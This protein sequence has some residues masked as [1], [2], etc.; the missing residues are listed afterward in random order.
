MRK[1]FILSILIMSLAFSQDIAVQ[2]F[3]DA[4]DIYTA[5][6]DDEEITE[7]Q[8][9]D[10]LQLFEEK[11]EINSGNLHRLRVIPGVD[12]ADIEVLE[13]ILEEK[14]DFHD[15]DD[16][17]FNYPG[18]FNLIESFIIVIPPSKRKLNGYA[19]VYTRRD[20]FSPSDWDDPYHKGKFLLRSGKWSGEIGFRQRGKEIG[21]VLNRMIKYRTTKLEFIAGNYRSKELG[22]GLLVGK[23]LWVPTDERCGDQLDYFQ[24]PYYGYQ[25]G[26]YAHWYLNKKWNFKTALSTN[27]FNAHSYQHLVSGAVSYAPKK[28]GEIGIVLYQGAI[29][30]FDSIGT[31]GFS[32]MGASVFG[33][34]IWAKWKFRN[35]TGILDNGAWGTQCLLFSPRQNKMAFDM[36]FWAYHPEFYGLYSNGEND[37]RSYQYYYPDDDFTFKIKSWTKGEIGGYGASRFPIIG[38]LSFT[39]K[40]LYFHTTNVADNGGEG[41]LGL[42]YKF[43]RKEYLNFY[44]SRR[45][46]G[47]GATGTTKDKISVSAK[48]V[49]SD[50]FYA[51]GNAYFKWNIDDS[52]WRNEYKF[53]TKLNYYL[54]PDLRLGIELDRKDSNVDTD[55]TG[56]W[57]IMPVIDLAIA[58]IDWETKYQFRK[59][60]ESGE[61][62]LQAKINA[63]VGF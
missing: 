38:N 60:D 46:D 6:Y 14:G 40:G 36:K 11:L 7:E 19:K 62:S 37:K 50:K 13:A 45:W 10:L 56:Y 3:Q 52:E 43:N 9:Y 44:I 51:Q 5:Y 18:D 25:N 2:Y 58:G 34:Y 12:K 54:R 24:S 26:L 20:Y 53:N 21:T 35:E 8:Y 57:T 22:Y 1:W 27:Y 59:Y 30:D 63:Q 33:E 48:Y 23:Y 41:Y 55:E 39:L 4:D 47:A 17:Y 61:W 29:V 28:K 49:P 31:Y 15:I 16:V 32:Q 42:K